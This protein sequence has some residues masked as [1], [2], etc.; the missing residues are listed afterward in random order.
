M[1]YSTVNELSY[2]YPRYY[3]IG[4]IKLLTFSATF[5]VKAFI[6]KKIEATIIP[7]PIEIAAGSPI[8]FKYV[9][10]LLIVFILS[11]TFFF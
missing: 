5:S 1:I 3:N 7:A 10:F 6:A 4:I 2:L 9:R 11:I 8:L